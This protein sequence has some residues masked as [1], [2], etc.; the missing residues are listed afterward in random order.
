M[1]F[2]TWRSHSQALGE[3]LGILSRHR[4]L[5]WSMTRR[6]ITD[7]YAGQF[8]G[9]LWAIGHPLVL[10][11]VYVWV[12][13]VVFK[14]RIG[15][16]YELPRDYTAYLLSGLIPWMAFQEAMSKGTVVISTHANL[17]K[18]VVFP[19]E[20]LPVKGILASMLTQVV[21]SVLLLLYLAC[22]ESGLPWT[23]CL[24]PVLWVV[25]FLA[26]TG[27][28]YI[29]AAVGP[30]F[31]D[32]KDLVQVFC[33]VGMYFMPIFYLPAWVPETVRPFLYFN[34]F[35]YLAWCYQDC[36]YFGR[37]DHPWAWLVF[38]LGSFV[39]SYTGYRVFRRLK[40]CFGSVL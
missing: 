18:Q 1:K 27:T 34:P 17:V 29:L 7:R 10:M 35:S 25:Q 13:T 22:T 8:L 33:L 40:P 32:V 15:G 28:C 26:M 23:I 6:E 20:I 2:I 39:L 21:A 19:I 11:A 9:S 24:L 31:R 38:A 37:F 5:T 36:L 14:T 3:L 16:T 4:Q 12:F 30:Y